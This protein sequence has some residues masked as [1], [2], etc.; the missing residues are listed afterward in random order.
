VKSHSKSQDVK[1]KALT[2]INFTRKV[3]GLETAVAFGNSMFLR[4]QYVSGL[5]WRNSWGLQ[6]RSID[7]SPGVPVGSPC[8]DELMANLPSVNG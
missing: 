4:Q 2:T 5:A 6:N 3:V 8:H 1:Q 7:N